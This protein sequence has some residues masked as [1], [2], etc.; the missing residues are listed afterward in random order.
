MKQPQT[1]KILQPK[2]IKH[3]LKATLVSAAAL[4][5]GGLFLVR[6]P[7]LGLIILIPNLFALIF[8]ADFYL[9][10]TWELFLQTLRGE[11]IPNIWTVK[12]L[13]FARPDDPVKDQQ[14]TRYL[15]LWFST[16]FIGI[17][18]S[19]IAGYRLDKREQISAKG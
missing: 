1:K 4:P 2:P 10:Q 8:L 13:F 19:A 11:I 15:W 16:Y 17:I 9:A 3:W 6:Q 5:A 12:D 7:L 14:L 18:V